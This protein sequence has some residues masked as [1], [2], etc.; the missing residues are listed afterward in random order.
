MVAVPD[1]ATL[2]REA[3]QQAGLSQRELARRAGTS[4][5]AVSA[6]E[7]GRK[8]PGFATVTRLLAA[9]DVRLR[10]HRS[11]AGTMRDY[12]ARRS[13]TPGTQPATLSDTVARV[14]AGE[15]LWV[16]VREFL[17]G[18]GLVAEVSG[19]Q[20]VQ[21]LI[22]SRPPD[23]ADHRVGALAGALAE[24][25]AATHGLDRPGWAVE[26]ERFLEAFWFPHARS[27]FDALAV[28]SAPAAFRRRGIFVDA[29][30]LSRC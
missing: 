3:R 14:A 25:L 13:T 11:G 30:S 20:A 24:H 19:P 27:A 5:S 22:R 15:D 12:L 7:S 8:E 28:R 26:P 16:A 17:D 4:Q 1:A 10:P 2:I 29:S 9:A 6:Y 23:I 18:V 21:S